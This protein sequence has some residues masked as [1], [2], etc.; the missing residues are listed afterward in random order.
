MTSKWD[1][2]KR[3]RQWA[4]MA[5]S[6]VSQRDIAKEFDVSEPY[7]SRRIKRHREN[8]GE[9]IRNDKKES[10]A[11]VELVRK[12][13]ENK[14]RLSWSSVNWD[15]MDYSLVVLEALATLLSRTPVVFI[16]RWHEEIVM[17]AIA[18][19]FKLQY[20]TGNVMV[21]KNGEQVQ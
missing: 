18:R 7:V 3:D 8:S 19:Y 10:A 21:V 11:Y 16:G 20:P 4:E 9:N 12:G 1:A 2:M 15:G 17:K 5:D 14:A 13:E 6:G